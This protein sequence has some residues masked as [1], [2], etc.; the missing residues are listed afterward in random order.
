[1][2]RARWTDDAT[3]TNPGGTIEGG[4]AIVD[5]LAG[6]PLWGDQVALSPSY[7]AEY[8]IQGN[9]AGFEFEC[10][11]VSVSGED[12]LTMSLVDPSGRQDGD[13]EIV[14]HSQATGTMV[15]QGDRWLF[16]E[17][18]GSLMPA[19]KQGRAGS[20]RPVPRDVRLGRGVRGEPSSRGPTDPSRRPVPRHARRAPPPPVIANGRSSRTDSGGSVGWRSLERTIPRPDSFT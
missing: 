12:A 8:D 3:F 5:C 1:M 20:V 18:T 13:A 17:F 10:V 7:K 14:Q 19:G 6:T 11:L 15:R 9:R 4:D 16:Q 2:T